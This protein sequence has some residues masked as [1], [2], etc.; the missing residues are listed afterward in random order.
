LSALE[1][2]KDGI[3]PVRGNPGGIERVEDEGPRIGF[4]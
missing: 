3:S 4:G 2:S 1:A